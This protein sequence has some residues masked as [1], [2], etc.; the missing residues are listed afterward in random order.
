MGYI[1][2]YNFY[3]CTR[4]ISW[5]KELH[6]KKVRNMMKKIDNLL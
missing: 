2:P 6:A 4:E 5:H 3:F 1:I